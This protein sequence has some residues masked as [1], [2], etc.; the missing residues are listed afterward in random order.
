MTVKIATA[1]T[2]GRAYQALT[3]TDVP[4]G[5]ILERR[6]EQNKRNVAKNRR[7]SMALR[8]LHPKDWDRLFDEQAEVIDSS[9]LVGDPCLR[10]SMCQGV[11]GLEG[12]H[13]EGCPGEDLAKYK[14]T[15][16]E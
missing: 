4:S 1:S 15:K 9:P 8:D 10:K 16:Q 13:S 12:M 2:T 3:G 6:N 5:L 11:E 7:T 14:R